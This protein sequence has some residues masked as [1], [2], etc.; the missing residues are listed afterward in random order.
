MIDLTD[1]AITHVMK[2]L[3]VEGE[4]VRIAL[5]PSGCAG[6]EYNID[7]DNDLTEDDIIIDFGKFGVLIDSMSAPMVDGSTLDVITE[8]MNTVVKLINPKETHAC[9]CGLSV[10]F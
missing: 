4:Y 1:R 8:G 6:F 7:W 5:K 3:R 9:G 10:Q 2:N